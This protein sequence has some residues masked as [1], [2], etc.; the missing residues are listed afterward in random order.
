MDLVCLPLMNLYVILGMNWL[1]FNH[2]HINYFN[3]TVSLQEFDVSDEFFV[4]AKQV[5]EFV[6]D[7][8]A[9]FMILSSMKAKSK[10]LLG[11]LP[12]VSDF[13]EVFPDD[14]KDLPPEREVEFTIDLVSSTS[15]VSMAPYRMYASEL[16]ESKK[17]LVDL[18]EKKFVRPSVSLWDASV[19]LVKKKDNIYEAMC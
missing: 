5:N 4:S 8:D 9:V 12:V 17:L 10:V 18:I 6:K 14:I 15:L 19:L 13:P 1:E 11:E 16:S 3:K 7:D 2:D